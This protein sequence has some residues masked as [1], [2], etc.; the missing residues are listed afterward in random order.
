VCK[1]GQKRRERR[2]VGR[3]GKEMG[4]LKERDR[5]EREGSKY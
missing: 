1:W 2:G 5:D 4:G 3:G